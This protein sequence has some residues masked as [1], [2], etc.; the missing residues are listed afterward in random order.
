MHPRYPF[1]MYPLNPFTMH[2]VILSQCTPLSFTMQAR[3]PF[4]L[5]PWTYQC[6]LLNH[7]LW[8]RTEEDVEVQ[9]TSDNMETDTRIGIGLKN[10]IYRNK[11]SRLKPSYE[12]SKVN[13]KVRVY[14]LDIPVG[15]ADFRLI[16]PRYWNSLFYSLISLGRMQRKFMQLWECHSTKFRSIWYP[17]DGWTEAVWIQSLPKTYKSPALRES[18]PDPLISGPTP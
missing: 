17:L 1:T 4:K 16:T 7:I 10:N 12:S 5:D 18:T 3:N 6:I 9:H 2:P 13:V 14:S 8:R 15:S 11:D